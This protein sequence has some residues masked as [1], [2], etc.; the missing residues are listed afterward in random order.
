[1]RQIPEAVT[2]RGKKGMVKANGFSL[3]EL[4]KASLSVEEASK[5]GL[6]VDEIRSYYD[7]R[8]VEA[9]VK[10]LKR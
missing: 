5:L 4:R 7:M 3:E 1:M 10:F 2:Y 8:N 9:L 6:K